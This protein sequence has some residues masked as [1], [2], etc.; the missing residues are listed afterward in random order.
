VNT[1]HHSPLTTHLNLDRVRGDFPILQ[2]PLPGGAPLVYLDTAASAQKPRVVSEKM[3]E[4]YQ[5]YYANAHRGLYNFGVRIDEEFEAARAKV[6]MFL[7]AAQPEEIIFTSGTTMAV[8]LVANAWGR[9]FLQPGDE[10]LVNVMEHHANLVPW[11]QIA[12]E[13]GAKLRYL[14]LTPD[15]RLDLSR[16]DE[17]LTDRTRLVAVAGMSNVL[18]TINPIDVLAAKAK[19]RGALIF[20]DAAQSVPH[21]PM[22]VRDPQVDFLAFSGHKL[23]GPTGVGV[24]FGR[25]ELLEAMDPFLCGGH[26]ISEV[27][28]DSSSWAELPAKFEAGTAPIAEIIG[29]GA[30][31]DY[32]AAVGLDA[33]HVHEQA[34]L[35]LAH[36]RLA[37]IPGVQVYGPAPEHKGAII[38]FTVDGV[39]PHDVAELVNRK[40]VALRAGHHCAMLL[41]DWLDVPAT[42]RASFALYNTPADVEA[43]AEAIVFARKKM[44]VA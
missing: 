31:V 24:L 25:R 22:N 9:K 21:L 40:G 37:E 35:E 41:H 32:V 18:G 4:C 36:M 19:E 8:N 6:R 44:R 42:A 29:L 26:M 1:T 15:G 14:P 23:Y 34:L 12:Q 30:A 38:A 5:T 2:Q 11:Q 17:F 13:K 7:G 16:L 10:L 43:L 33:I 20:V 39:H 3:V 27:R 28:P